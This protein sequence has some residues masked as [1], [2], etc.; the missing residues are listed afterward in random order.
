M[1]SLLARLATTALPALRGA[2]P[3]ASAPG[4]AV[5][6]AAAAA[7]ASGAPGLSGAVAGAGAPPLTPPGVRA[8][9]TKTAVK[10]MCRGCRIVSRGK[11]V[12]V[13]C[14]ENP[15][16]KQRTGRGGAAHKP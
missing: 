8:F 15:R 13:L 6:A 4:R 7:S 10:R 3:T 2:A 5:A 16:H 9:K 14:D 11:R 1:A 12:Y